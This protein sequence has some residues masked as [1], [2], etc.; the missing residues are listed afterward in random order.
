M[1]L[2]Q[3][4]TRNKQAADAILKVNL[5]LLKLIKKLVDPLLTRVSSFIMAASYLHFLLCYPRPSFSNPRKSLSDLMLS[6]DICL[7]SYFY[8]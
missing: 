8:E 1:R 5:L 6:F 3:M 7:L 4:E 2:R